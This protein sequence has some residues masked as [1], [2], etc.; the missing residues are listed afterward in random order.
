MQARQSVINSGQPGIEILS[1]L[2][3]FIS[4]VFLLIPGF[5]TDFLG[6]MLLINPVRTIIVKSFIR[7]AF[8]SFKR[9]N[10][11]KETIKIRIILILIQTINS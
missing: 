5:F 10:L 9:Q 7:R 6:A 4:G 1:N 8:S 2:A 3:L 11:L